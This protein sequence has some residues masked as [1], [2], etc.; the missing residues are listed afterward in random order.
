MGIMIYSNCIAGSI[1]ILTTLVSCADEADTQK[2][3][4]DSISQK[5]AMVPDRKDFQDAIDGKKN[6]FV[7]PKKRQ[8][9]DRC[10]Y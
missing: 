9:Y 8:W 10:H 4:K 7:Y 2:T 3:N 5:T 1:I 6:R